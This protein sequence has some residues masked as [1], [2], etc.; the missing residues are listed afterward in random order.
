MPHI[1]SFTGQ[2]PTPH[3]YL[4]SVDRSHSHFY[5]EPA[6]LPAGCFTA[7][8]RR[9]IRKRLFVLQPCNGSFVSV[10]QIERRLDAVRSMCHHSHKRLTACFQGQH[11]TDADKRHVSSR[12][13]SALG[14]CLFEG[15]SP[16]TGGFPKQHQ[17]LCLQICTLSHVHAH[18]TCPPTTFF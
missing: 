16:V 12:C 11:G 2:F 6:N 18:N 10:C 4:V 5:Q 9:R 3:S 14:S 15:L 7:S 8:R 17:P 13:D 1:L